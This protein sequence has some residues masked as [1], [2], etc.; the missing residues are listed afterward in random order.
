VAA[1]HGAAPDAEALEEVRDVGVVVAA[2]LV[3]VRI[4]DDPAHAV[5]VHEDVH[6]AR[7]HRGRGA[8]SSRSAASRYSSSGWRTQRRP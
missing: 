4:D 5:E 1:D 3:R 2:V 8:S 7:V 6:P